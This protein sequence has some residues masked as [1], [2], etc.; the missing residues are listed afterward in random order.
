ME[1]WRAA[2]VRWGDT[3][4]KVALLLTNQRASAEAIMVAAVCR[5]FGDVPPAQPELALYSALLTQRQ[6]RG[7]LFHKRVLPRAL[8]RIAPHDRA[9]LGLWLLRNLDGAQL[10]AIFSQSP[11]AIVERLGAILGPTAST[12][13]PAPNTDGDHLTLRSWLASQLGI[14]PQPHQHP[15]RCDHCRSAQ[16]GWQHTIASLRATLHETLN[17]ERLPQHCVD[18]IEDTLQQAA[19]V[20][21]WWQERRVGMAVLFTGVAAILALLVVPRSFSPASLTAAPQSARALV[22]QTLDQW[23]ALPAS[24]VLHRR[25]WALDPRLASSAPLITDLW[26]SAADTGR[27]RVEVRHNNQLVEWQVA[28]GDGRLD[29]AADP[30]YSACPW[31]T[32]ASATLGMLDQAALTFEAAP[33]QQRAARDARLTGGAYGMGYSILHQALSAPDL[34]SF[35]TRREHPR[36]LVVLGYTDPQTQPPRQILLRIDPSARQLDSVQEIGQGGGQAAA[37]DL[38]RLEARDAAA[39]IPAGLPRWSQTTK[40][41]ELFDPSCPALNRQHV[42]GL[43]TLLADPQQ[44]YIPHTLPPG[45]DRAALL[46]LNPLVSSTDRAPDIVPRGSVTTFVGRNRWLAI[47]D[48]DWHSAGRTT[49][50]ITRGAWYVEINE[51][52]RPGIWSLRLRRSHEQQDTFSPTIAVYAGGWTQTE[53]LAVI[54]TLTVFDAESW[55]KLNAAFIDARPL[56][57]PVH[58]SIKRA[59][60]ALQPPPGRAI[61]TV[62]KT[63]VRPQPTSPQPGDPYTLPQQLRDPATLIRTQWHVHDS[64]PRRLFR[65]LYTLLDDTPYSLIASD[66]TQFKAFFSAQGRVY[67]GDPAILPFQPQQP[68]VEM[69]QFLLRTSAPISVDHTADGLTLQ[70]FLPYRSGSD[71]ELVSPRLPQSPWLDGL[72]DGTLVQQLQLD[73]ATYQPQQ[74][75]IRHRDV[76]GNERTLLSSTLIERREIDTP[77]AAAFVELPSLPQEALTMNVTAS[78]E[79]T[80]VMPDTPPITRTLTFAAADITVGHAPPQRGSRTELSSAGLWQ[81]RWDSFAG[82]DAWHQMVYRFP[83]DTRQITITQGPRP[84]IGHMLRYQSSMQR[85]T[86]SRGT[87]V[88]IAGQPTTVWLLVNDDAAALVFEIDHLLVHIAGPRN[89]LE[90]TVLERLPELDWT[91]VQP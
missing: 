13:P 61:Y 59:L 89:L 91:S 34:R 11:T 66:G 4:F 86:T 50:E 36:T 39:A 60:A 79:T 63:T 44:W 26:L 41:A 58:E 52:P 64:S 43:N 72:D 53:L 28:D 16:S 78:S 40:R 57:Q 25:V 85:W 1:I 62:A 35:G 17:H 49:T 7:S 18:A 81:Q 2:V 33:D 3:L 90:T 56:A 29:Y 68:G 38:W 69:I 47:S 83:P 67:T 76:H 8:R 32:E 6:P 9:L 75:T 27:H 71:I 48:L 55:L 22:Q 51:Q 74:L 21:P 12:Q 45:T 42:A 24:D 73:P 65:D 15:Q 37:R 70:Q 5:V 77:A 87:P 46:T 31:R 19:T 84:L 20:Q 30:A 23:T 10:A 82:S 14:Q 88:T 80:V 54:D